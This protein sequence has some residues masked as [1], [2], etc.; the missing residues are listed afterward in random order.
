VKR[1]LEEP[2][3]I[4]RSADHDGCGRRTTRRSDETSETKTLVVGCRAKN[5][6]G[7]LEDGYMH[8]DALRIDHHYHGLRNTNERGNNSPLRL[9]EQNPTTVFLQLAK[10]TQRKSTR[11]EKLKIISTI[12]QQKEKK[13]KKKSLKKLIFR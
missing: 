2:R 13:K 3:N 12:L 4:G 8:F 10:P 5:I 6:V 1:Q 11:T 7:F 9:L